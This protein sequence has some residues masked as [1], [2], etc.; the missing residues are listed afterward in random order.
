MTSAPALTEEDLDSLRQ[1]DTCMVASAVETFN[2]R[3]RN[4]GFTNGSIHCMF[5]DA[6]PMVGYALTARLRAGEP[7]IMG[8]DVPRSQRSLAQGSADSGASDPGA[9]RCRRSPGIGRVRGQRTR[10]DPKGPG[11]HRTPDEWSRARVALRSLDGTSAIRGKRCGLACVR[12]HFRYWLE[13][14]DRRNGNPAG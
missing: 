9:G 13:S 12:A 8:G 1:F 3:L 11:L 7:P 10:R 14:D 2:L 5:P 6:P 4:T